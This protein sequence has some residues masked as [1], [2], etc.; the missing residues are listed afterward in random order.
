MLANKDTSLL[1]DISVK[2]R[3]ED[4]LLPI[5]S[6]AEKKLQ[7]LAPGTIGTLTFTIMASPDAEAK[8]YPTPIE[9]TYHDE[10]GAIHTSNDT[11][12]L[13]VGGKPQY[14]INIEQSDAFTKNKKGEI[15]ISIA[16]TGASQ[17]KFLTLNLQPTENYTVTSN[18]KSYLGNLDSDDFETTEFTLITH[19]QQPAY[20]IIPF[21]CN[22]PKEIPLVF[23]LA[24]QDAYNTPQDITQTIPLPLYTLT[25]I[26]AYQLAPSTGFGLG[27]IVI[28]I[29]LLIYVFLAYKNW[30][31]HKNFTHALKYGLKDEGRGV[32]NLL[33]NL[34][35]R[36]LK[37]LPRRM[38]DFFL[39]P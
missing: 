23:K 37:R 13:L 1:K 36:K 19:I 2:L 9:L 38:R 28:G 24:Y 25:Q 18:T 22:D 34:R 35:W 4:E 10:T 15:I 6:T 7:S 8:A 31:L 12:G 39:E 26:K 33:G 21:T 17:I 30:R 3:L 14:D 27:T 5:G 29:L 20:C 32:I 11:I 16:N